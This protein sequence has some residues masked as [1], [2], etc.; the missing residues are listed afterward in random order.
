M[1]GSRIHDDHPSITNKMLGSWMDGGNVL[2]RPGFSFLSEM[3]PA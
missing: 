1:E 3:R 2:E